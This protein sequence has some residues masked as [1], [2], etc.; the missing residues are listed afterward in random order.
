MI[1][2]ILTTAA[3]AVLLLGAATTASAEGGFHEALVLTAS[4]AT[5]N[6]LIVLNTSGAVIKR[7]PPRGKAVSAATPVASPRAATASR[8]SISDRPTCRSSNATTGAAGSA[9]SA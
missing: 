5:T 3:A 8:W 6:E 2:R 9:S 1:E 4:N 7:I